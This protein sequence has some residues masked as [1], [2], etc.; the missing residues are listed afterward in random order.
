MQ[1]V[2]LV[3]IISAAIYVS[4]MALF[5]A[6]ILATQSEFEREV[7][8]HIETATQLRAAASDAERANAAKA[9]FLA[10]MSH[11][12]RTPLNAVIGYSQI[13]LE[14]T[15]PELDAQGVEDLNKI[16]AAGNQLLTLVNA[17]LDLSKIEAGKMEVYARPVDLPDLLQT[18]VDR[19]RRD[20][21]LT[22][23]AIALTLGEPLGPVQID[24]DKLEQILAA[25][26]DNALRYAPHSDVRVAAK[27]T[28][29]D[30]G[31]QG[32][33]IAVSD[34]GPGIPRDL[35]PALFETFSDL[36]AANANN[37][38]GPGLGLPLAHKLCGLLGGT[39]SVSSDPKSGTTFIV[40]LPGAKSDGA[41]QAPPSSTFAEAA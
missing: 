16:H 34:R 14:D 1:G 19:W 24:S 9:D 27:F 35:M 29:E 36:E 31:S 5:Y 38:G 21:R 13:L 28:K 11:E 15:D 41:R 33:E 30:D 8:K 40:A 26:L 10:K 2:G 17:I 6:G 32:V 20:A 25:L 18:V 3:S 4:M 12:L 7:R 23:R 39:L 22:G 37:S